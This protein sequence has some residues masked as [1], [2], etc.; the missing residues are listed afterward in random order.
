V[1]KYQCAGHIILS[2]GTVAASTS[3][4]NAAPVEASAIDI[5][6]L[7]QRYIAHYAPNP[8]SEGKLCVSRAGDGLLRKICFPEMT[9][10]VMYCT[11]KMTA[12]I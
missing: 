5:G 4:N 7:S 3:A 9:E 12:Q 2:E 11:A 8:F 10:R 6:D 1:S